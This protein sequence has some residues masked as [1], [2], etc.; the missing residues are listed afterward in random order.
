MSDT[1]AR[2]RSTPPT[3]EDGQ[4]VDLQVDSS[5]NLKVVGGTGSASTMVQGVAANDAPIDG[6]PVRIGA[7]ARTD[8]ITA[9]GTTNTVNLLATTVG[10]LIVRPYTLPELSWNYAA[11]TGG[12]D[13]SSTAVTVKAAAAAGI[14]NYITSLQIAHATLG[15]ATEFAIRDGAGGTVLWRTLLN[16]TAMPLQH[17][18]FPVPLVGTAA[19]LLEIITLTAVTGDVLVNLQGYS[20]P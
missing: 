12:I 10:A 16:T 17:I 9:V 20:A 6:N 14:R 2:Y 4:W 13:N 19:T 18:E 5:G 1:R 3:V 11:A 8:N 15:A 7:Q